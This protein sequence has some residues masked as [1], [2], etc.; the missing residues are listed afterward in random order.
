M[1]LFMVFNKQQPIYL[2]ILHIPLIKK[3]HINNLYFKMFR[4]TLKTQQQGNF[5]SQ[6]CSLVPMVAEMLQ[7]L[8]FLFMCFMSMLYKVLF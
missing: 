8:R 3:T 7:K 2:N 1:K 5:R 4:I 6:I